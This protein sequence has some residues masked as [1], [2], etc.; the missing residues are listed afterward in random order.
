MNFTSATRGRWTMISWA[1]P[2]KKPGDL[3]IPGWRVI[4]SEPGWLHVE[5][6]HG[7]ALSLA[8]AKLPIAKKRL[9]TSAAKALS[10][11]R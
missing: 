11:A 1:G 4:A 3:L 5:P 7:R 9:R 8:E 6:V 2:E 10:M